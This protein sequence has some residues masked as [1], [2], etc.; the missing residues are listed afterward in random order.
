MPTKHKKLVMEEHIGQPPSKHEMREF[1]VGKEGLTFCK[2][3]NAVYYKK[4]WHHSLRK[5]DNLPENMKVKFVVCPADQTILDHQ[6]EGEIMIQN[7]PAKIQS[8]LVNLI[9]GYTKR[10]YE[11]DPMDRLIEAK[12]TRDSLRVTT[13]ENQMAV[14]L[15]KKIKESFKKVSLE[16]HYAKPP[17]ETVHIK[18]RFDSNKAK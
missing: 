14:K 4:S 9:H 13:T 15:A 3:C 6:F 8:D 1:P 12:K 10:S 5:Y 18:M 2:I 17:L 7:I 11:K 16:I